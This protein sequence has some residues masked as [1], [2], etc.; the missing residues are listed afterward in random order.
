[1][2]SDQKEKAPLS[3]ELGL[4]GIFARRISRVDY[5]DT[6]TGEIRNLSERIG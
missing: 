3:V 6:D 4:P 1:M 5:H 2:F